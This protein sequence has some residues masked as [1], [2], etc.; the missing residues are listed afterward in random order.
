MGLAQVYP[1]YIIIGVSLSEP[2]TYVKNGAIVH[3][4][5]T[6]AKKLQ[7]TKYVQWFICVQLNLNMHD[8]PA[9]TL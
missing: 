8:N 7:H 3:A 9:D 4:Q 1:N 5:R 2:Y 6:A